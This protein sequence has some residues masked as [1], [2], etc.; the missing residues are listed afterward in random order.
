[1]LDSYCF[2]IVETGVDP[3]DPDTVGLVLTGDNLSGTWEINAL[4]WDDNDFIMLTFS[5]GNGIPDSYVGYLLTEADGTSGDY[6]T[7]FLNPGGNG[8]NAKDISNV[9]AYVIATV[10][11]LPAA[12]PMFLAALGGL[13][14]VGRRRR[15]IAGAA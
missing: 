7:P 14:W 11:P 5:D 8:G 13:F 12:L 9:S 1:M 4:A 15:G 2:A 6:T 10:S 3:L